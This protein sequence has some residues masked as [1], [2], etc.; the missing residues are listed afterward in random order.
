LRSRTSSASPSCEAFD[1]ED[2]KLVATHSSPKEPEQWADFRDPRGEVHRVRVGELVGASGKL[3]KV[4]RTSVSLAVRVQKGDESVEQQR[5]VK[6][7]RR[8]Q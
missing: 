7:P 1:V 6:L 4:G 3:E 2:L 8:K 5:I